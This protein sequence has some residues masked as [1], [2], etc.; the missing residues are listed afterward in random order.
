MDLAG[1]GLDLSISKLV[2]LRNNL[3]DLEALETDGC[4]ISGSYGLMGGD[5]CMGE[6]CGQETRE[7]ELD[8]ELP[9]K[10]AVLLLDEL[11]LL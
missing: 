2:H 3:G 5:S 8:D 6:L 9:G 10:D 11:V 7:L 1:K 4:S